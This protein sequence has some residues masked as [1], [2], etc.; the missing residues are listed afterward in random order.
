MDSD[1]LYTIKTGDTFWTLE[2]EWDIP[3]GTLQQLNPQ[4]N[5]QKLKVGQKI[6]V[7]TI[8]YLE[9][10]EPFHNKHFEN[11]FLRMPIDNLRIANIHKPIGMAS[12]I[13]PIKSNYHYKKNTGN[14]SNRLWGGVQ[15]IGGVIEIILGGVGGIL[16]SETGGGAV[17][18]YMVLINGIDNTATG[19]NQMVSGISEDTYLHKGVKGGLEM[20]G[21]DYQV[22][23]DIATV[24]DLSTIFLGG[25]N[26]VKVISNGE[27]IFIK[28][29]GGTKQWIRLGSSYSFNLQQKT[30]LSLKWGA[31]KK[32]INEIGNLKLRKL[33]IKLRKTK[34]PG[35]NWRVKDP[36][37]FHFKK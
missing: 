4:L 32:H 9:I 13:R 24:V 25:T 22:S 18:G 1:N 5:P 10:E 2:N 30:K 36:G 37:H 34:I 23:E 26:T 15:M 7:P 29:T 8:F 28:A 17:I 14:L 3:H 27:S 33:N 31:G 21:A 6:K 20:L 16:T 11:N 12:G 35:E 19:F